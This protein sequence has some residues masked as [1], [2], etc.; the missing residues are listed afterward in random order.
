MDM[1]KREDPEINQIQTQNQAEQDDRS[2]KTWKKCPIKM[3]RTSTRSNSG[4][5]CV[6]IHTYCTLFPPNKHSI[7]FTTFRLYVE[8][9]FHMQLMG[10]LATGP[11]G[12][13]I[14]VP[15]SRCCS[16]TSIPLIENQNP[17]SSHCR[18]RSPEIR[19]RGVRLDLWI[20]TP[21]KS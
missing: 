8:T 19:T 5:S 21:W 17:A 4:S 14:R 3:M 6:S 18:L 9:L 10:Y 13:V 7:C 15:C 20:K 1:C 12:L 16:L 11:G 2:K